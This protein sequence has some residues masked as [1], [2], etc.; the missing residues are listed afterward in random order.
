MRTPNSPDVTLPTPPQADAPSPRL[1]PTP[2]FDAPALPIGE[3]ASRPDFPLCTLDQHVDIGG[4]AGVVVEIVLHSIK[5]RA[6]EGITQSFNFNRLRT[7]YGRKP[8]VVDPPRK[9]ERP[10]V[11]P[12][13]VVVDTEE[14]EEE[15]P[16][17]APE[18]AI[19][20][21]FSQPV[22]QIV[23]FVGR[24]DFPKCALGAHVEIGGYTGVVIEIVK[25]SLKV[26]SAGESTRSY[27]AAT[28]RKIY[29]ER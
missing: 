9:T 18:P 1:I 13:P 5:V 12:K 28:L 15:E 22:R 2:N 25:H 26:R 14:D 3:Y 21:D 8:E 7:L 10:P 20:P 17:V 23:E 27:N 11:A 16:E 19:R 6:R 29:G 24:P 4:Y